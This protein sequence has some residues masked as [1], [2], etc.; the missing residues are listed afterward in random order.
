MAPRLRGQPESSKFCETFRSR[1]SHVMIGSLFVLLVHAAVQLD[2]A[3]L[4]AFRLRDQ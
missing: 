2:K 1:L 4:T 3:E